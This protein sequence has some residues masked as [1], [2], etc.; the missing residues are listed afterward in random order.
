MGRVFPGATTRDSDR[1][2]GCDVSSTRGQAA[3]RE[4]AGEGDSRSVAASGSCAQV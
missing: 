4:L 2:E 1:G 3:A